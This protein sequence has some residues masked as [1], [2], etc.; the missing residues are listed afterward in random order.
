MDCIL[1]NQTF[2]AIKCLGR[3]AVNVEGHFGQGR[4][5]RF[6]SKLNYAPIQNARVPT[7][8]CYLFSSV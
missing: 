2:E 4:Q 6:Q 3:G 8:S 5:S 1:V 7:P